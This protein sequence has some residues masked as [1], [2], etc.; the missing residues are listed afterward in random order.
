MLGLFGCS[1]FS[2]F[3]LEVFHFFP[4]VATLWGGGG[5]GGRKIGFVLGEKRELGLEHFR[6]GAVATSSGRLFQST[7]VVGKVKT[8][9]WPVVG[10][11]RE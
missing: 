2:P 10:Y 6:V 1:D 3:F 5:R 4:Q 11:A 9:L 8:L 7:M